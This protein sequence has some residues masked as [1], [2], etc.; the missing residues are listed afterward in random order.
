MSLISA[1]ISRVPS[2][3]EGKAGHALLDKLVMSF[4]GMT[5]K[6][7]GGR[8]VVDDSLKAMMAEAKKAKKE[9]QID[10]VFFRHYNRLLIVIKLVIVEDTEG[11]LSPLIEREVGGFVEDVK[12][13]KADIMGEGAVGVV[14]EAIAEEIINLSLYLDNLKRKQELKKKFMEF[15]KKPL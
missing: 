2:T 10:Q 4:K 5:E 9:N 13:A 3:K 1:E 14:A 15:G 11:I 6:G 12:G 8:E 7:T